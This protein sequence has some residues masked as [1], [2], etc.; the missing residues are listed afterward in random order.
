MKK[1][2]TIYHQLSSPPYFYKV[3]QYVIPWAL[4]LSMILFI[5]GLIES[6]FI[7]P[8]DYQMKDAYR[9]IFV[10]VPAAWMSLFIYLIMGIAGLMTYV[11]RIKVAEAIM[12]ASAPIGT[13]FTGLALVTGML[14]GKPMWGTY[15]DWDARMTSELILLF[16]YIGIIKIYDLYSEDPR[17]AARLASLVAMIGIVNLVIIRYSVYWWSSIHQGASLSLSEGSSIRDWGMLRPLLVM[18][19]A[20]K[21]YYIYSM[22]SRAQLHILE[23]EKSKQW[24]QKTISKKA[25]K[26]NEN[27]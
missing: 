21:F 14:W 22:C 15:W 18:A 3:C 7:A 2:I 26:D 6:L 25:K 10:H 17:K 9:I 4:W 19:L 16:L 12:M 24:V 20:T 11:W 8:I 5:W 1:L 13:L 27:D 23:T